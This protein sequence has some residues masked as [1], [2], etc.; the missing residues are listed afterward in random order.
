MSDAKK[1]SI[2]LKSNGYTK[3]RCGSL[4]LRAMAETQNEARAV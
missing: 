3:R 4:I 1:W 2:E